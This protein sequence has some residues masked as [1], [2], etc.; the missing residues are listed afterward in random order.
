MRQVA[1]ASKLNITL[2]LKPLRKSRD[3]IDC[4]ININLNS[5]KYL[6]KKINTIINNICK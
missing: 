1:K 2:F 3:D 5:I 6:I 4:K